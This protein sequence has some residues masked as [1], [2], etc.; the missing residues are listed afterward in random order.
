MI[1]FLNQVI[2][3]NWKLFA[4]DS[5]CYQTANAIVDIENTSKIFEAIADD[6]INDRLAY[7]PP[8]AQAD[9]RTV[10]A[11]ALYNVLTYTSKVSTTTENTEALDKQ[12]KD[13]FLRTNRKLGEDAFRV[14]CELIDQVGERQIKAIAKADFFPKLIFKEQNKVYRVLNHPFFKLIFDG[15]STDWKD[16]AFLCMTSPDGDYNTEERLFTSHVKYD[17]E[18]FHQEDT[19]HNMKYQTG[20]GCYDVT[21]VKTSIAS[22]R[23]KPTT[24]K[25]WFSE[26][27]RDNVSSM[28]TRAK[29]ATR[30]IRL[31]SLILDHYCEVHLQSCDN[32]V[33]KPYVKL[34]RAAYKFQTWRIKTL[35]DNYKRF[36]SNENTPLLPRKGRYESKSELNTFIK[37]YEFREGSKRNIFQPGDVDPINWKYVTVKLGTVPK[38]IT[39]RRTI[40]PISEGLFHEVYTIDKALRQAFDETFPSYFCFRDQSVQWNRLAAGWGTADASSASDLISVFQVVAAFPCGM[41]KEF[42]LLRPCIVEVD[43]CVFCLFMYGGMGHS[44]T[45]PIETYL[46]ILGIFSNVPDGVGI[47]GYGD[48]I[49]IQKFRDIV[50]C[51][52]RTYEEFGWKL[53]LDKSFLSPDTSNGESC[54]AFRFGSEIWT[55]LRVSRKVRLTEENTVDAELLLAMIAWQRALYLNGYKAAAAHLARIL[56]KFGVTGGGYTAY[57][58]LSDDPEYAITN[59]VNGVNIWATSIDLSC[60]KSNSR[61]EIIDKVAYYV[62]QYYPADT[63]VDYVKYQEEAVTFFLTKGREQLEFDWQEKAHVVSTSEAARTFYVNGI[64]FEVPELRSSI[65]RDRLV[66][67]TKVELVNK[68]VERCYIPVTGNTMNEITYKLK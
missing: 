66:S 21:K 41:W 25:M 48:D 35:F 2:L 36:R 18:S 49:T 55:L 24:W 30:F 11:G 27:V 47:T 29:T 5:G 16:T 44:L 65:N 31:F 23:E 6:L 67:P 9:L 51:I 10:S 64:E 37:R 45:F 53:N 22:E 33:L 8:F 60:P 50:E 40:T 14:V 17:Y 12:A 57:E 52:A 43:S 38:S 1:N 42:V 56:K 3:D 26:I 39:S 58:W 15:N 4:Q 19:I 62:N 13:K 59:D 32:T 28:R 34:R 61:K 46:F 63:K 68:I 7:L 20:Y 54:G